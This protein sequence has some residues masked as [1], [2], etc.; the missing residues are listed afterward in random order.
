MINGADV[1]PTSANTKDEIINYLT[2][3]NIEFDPNA[4]K[5]DLLALIK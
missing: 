3:H 5:D 2:E 4:K 1:K